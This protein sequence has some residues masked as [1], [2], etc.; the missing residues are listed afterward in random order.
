[1]NGKLWASGTVGFAAGIVATLLVGMLLMGGMM[2]RRG[3]WRCGGW[4]SSLGTE[5]AALVLYPA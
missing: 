2:V 1:M 3:Y 4:N 5:D